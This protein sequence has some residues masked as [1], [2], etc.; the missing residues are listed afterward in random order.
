ME[1]RFAW[2][3]EEQH[4]AGRRCFLHEVTEQSGELLPLRPCTGDGRLHAF[5]RPFG[6]RTATRAGTG[7]RPRRRSSAATSAVVPCTGTT[8][9]R[10]AGAQAVRSAARCATATQLSP[11]AVRQASTCRLHTLHKMDNSHSAGIRRA[12]LPTRRGPESLRPSL[13]RGGPSR[14]AGPGR[15]WRA[16]SGA[17]DRGRAPAAAVLSRGSQPPVRRT[18]RGRGPRLRVPEPWRPWSWACHP[19]RVRRPGSTSWR[20]RRSRHAHPPSR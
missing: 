18:P 12:D 20:S 11:P 3:Q 10:P 7:A 9:A 15:A 4:S 16:R 8:R 1:D 14:S 6:T 2:R 17:Q 13:R 19:R 5:H